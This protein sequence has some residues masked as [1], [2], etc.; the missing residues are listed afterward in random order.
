MTEPCA[1]PVPLEDVVAYL[2]GELDAGREASLEE[3]YFSCSHCAERLGWVGGLE[4]G[5]G[6]AI[7]RGMVDVVATRGF[8]E[9]LERTGAVLRRY[10][11]G[12]GEAV[13][14]TAAPGELMTILTLRPP[15]RPHV[16]LTLLAD[17][18]DRESGVRSQDERR[19]FQDPSTGEVV[20]AFP[21]DLMRSLGRHH[22]TL[23]VRYGDAPDADTSGPFDLEHTPSD[24]RRE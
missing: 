7:R 16:P 21:G 5:I 24:E 2:R 22:V 11:L 19:V 3:H 4:A 12:V 18:L 15:L 13:N 20:L 17:V 10:E 14:C 1:T 6:E 9:R 8:V 23:R